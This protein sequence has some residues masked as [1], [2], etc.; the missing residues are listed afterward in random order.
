MSKTQGERSHRFSQLVG[1]ELKASFARHETS[2]TEVAEKLG[3]SKSGYSRWLNAKPSMPIE[4]LLNTCELIGV[5]PREIVNDAYRRLLDE[6]G[7]YQHADAVNTTAM[8][9]DVRRPLGDEEAARIAHD[10]TMCETIGLDRFA[11]RIKTEDG[12]HA[13]N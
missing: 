11:D 10:E 12:I 9:V 4:T 5:D 6:A 8:P 3:H 2:Q 7:P 1:L 13:R